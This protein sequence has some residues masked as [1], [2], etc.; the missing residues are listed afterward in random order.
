MPV[1]VHQEPLPRRERQRDWS[2]GYRTR[3]H[4]FASH[5]ERATHQQ[6]FF[7]SGRAPVAHWQLAAGPE[8]RRI[9][10]IRDDVRDKW[11]RPQGTP[12]DTRR[13][14]P[15]DAARR[16]RP[17]GSGHQPLCPDGAV[18]CTGRHPYHPGSRQLS[19][20]YSGAGR[21]GC[22]RQHHRHQRCGA[23]PFRAR[24][25]QAAA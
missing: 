19:G 18:L 11:G 21:S 10:G 23:R 25:G 1:P 20:V 24:S 9:L 8:N 12:A 5:R 3:H 15:P 16:S 22:P 4:L 17:R 13:P 6:P 2:A 7:A 14:A